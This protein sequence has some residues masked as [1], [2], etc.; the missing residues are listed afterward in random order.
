MNVTVDMQAD[1]SFTME[2]IQLKLS[3]FAFAVIYVRN[4]VNGLG[5]VASSEMFIL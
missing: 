3:S 2:I 1:G 4:Q 5:S